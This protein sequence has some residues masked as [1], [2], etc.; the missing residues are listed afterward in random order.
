M[1]RFIPEGAGLR[2]E[3]EWRQ[4]QGTIDL[5]NKFNV[6]TVRTATKIFLAV[7]VILWE[8]TIVYRLFEQLAQP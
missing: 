7:T 2:E 8:I 6:T 1:S 5:S 4:L 3:E